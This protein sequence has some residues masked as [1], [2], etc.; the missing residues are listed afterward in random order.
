MSKKIK[1]S[2]QLKRGRP[3]ASVD[4]A[5]DV[6]PTVSSLPKNIIGSHMGLMQTGGQEHPPIVKGPALGKP[7]KLPPRIK[8][9]PPK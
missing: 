1:V 2:K 8:Q 3:R 7:A 9:A 5:K 4:T 6:T